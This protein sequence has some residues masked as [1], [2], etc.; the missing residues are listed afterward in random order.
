MKSVADLW[1][2]SWKDLSKYIRPT[3]GFFP[4]MIPGS[5]KMIDHT[6]VRDG[7]AMRSAR[8]LA[9]GMTSGLTSPSRPWFKLGFGD[10]DLA[11]YEPA[12]LWL[13]TCQERMMNVYSKSNIYGVL[14][15]TY[16]EIGV[17]GTAACAI[18]EDFEDC[19]NWKFSNA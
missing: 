7:T 5:G 16:E 2:P 18:L 19:P 11:N 10:P 8:V 4:G 12:K 13:D 3:R 6:V 17:F 9:A 1:T 15:T 14:H